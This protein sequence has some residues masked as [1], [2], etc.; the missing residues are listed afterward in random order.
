MKKLITI[1]L[2][3]L[4]LALSNAQNNT[5]IATATE[6]K[7]NIT[8]YSKTQ[9]TN[10]RA[11]SAIKLSNYY[12]AD[13]GSFV[14]VR[15]I[16]NMV[17]AMTDRYDRRASAIWVG[18]IEGRKLKVNYYY[19]PKGKAKGQGTLVFKINGSQLELETAVP[20]FN[21]KSIKPMAALPTKLP[22]D[23]RAWYRGDTLKN[24]TGRYKG[25]NVGRMYILDLDGQI[26]AYVRGARL[27][28]HTRPQFA[29]LFLGE[30]DGL[31]IK[32]CYID[33]PLG[34]TLGQGI[35]ELD[36]IGPQFVR[37]DRKH[38]FYGV[39]YKRNQDD[40]KEIIQ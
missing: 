6:I 21:F 16:G 18:K 1:S 35:T 8:D 3:I 14:F 10:T 40:I 25:E 12:E 30:K 19:M 32:G 33:L 11:K 38:F 4:S 20:E 17:Y 2:A 5:S 34:H 28:S 29:A 23:D 15:Q 22:I 27:T 26:I 31:K 7:N 36:I 9:E 39:N 37:S 13:D 24:L